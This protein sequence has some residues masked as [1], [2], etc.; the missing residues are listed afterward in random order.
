MKKKEQ[1][2]LLFNPSSGKGRS[3]KQKNKLEGY[4]T[5][6]GVAYDLTV[7]QSEDHLRRLAAEAVD[8]YQTIAAVGGDTTFN[9]VAGAI[10][11]RRKGNR[12]QSPSDSPT[13]AMIGTGSANDIVRGL[14]MEHLETACRAI[15][16]G[17]SRTMDA[18][19]IL[20]AGR[21]EPLYFLGT[22]SLG[23]GTTVNRYIEDYVRRRPR[24]SRVKPFDQTVP[25]LKAIHH[26][27]ASGAVPM[28]ARL[29][30]T[31]AVPGGE[32]VERNISFS[33]LVFHNTPFYAN[34]IK[35]GPSDGLFDGKLDCMLNNCRS[36]LNTLRVGLL[37][38]RGKHAHREEVE[39]FQADHFQL[40]PPAPGETFDIQ[41]DGD[42]IEK[43]GQL[44]ISI[45]PARLDVIAAHSHSQ[46]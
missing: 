25:G 46:P 4:L 38:Q 41:V 10:L 1:L 40:S 14:G 18:G 19:R 13:L 37:V 33:L 15:K 43:V 32:E 24:L 22:V 28:D 39:Q 29:Q 9:I 5:S 3:I 12:E 16:E 27:F 34:G 6:L 42:I 31:A 8:R 21:P 45:L 7:T 2:A 17:R 44:N 30:F 26:S 35:L 20:I 11:E 23:L 36:F